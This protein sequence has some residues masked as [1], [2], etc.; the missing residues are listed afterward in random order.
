M[1][2]STVIQII[3]TVTTT[4]TTV[5]ATITTLSQEKAVPLEAS[6]DPEGSKNLRLPDFKT[7]D[8]CRW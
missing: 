1:E 8:T 3:A 2:C 7:I 4:V 6:I 5:T